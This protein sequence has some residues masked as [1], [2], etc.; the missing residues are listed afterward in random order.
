MTHLSCINVN[1]VKR[2][3]RSDSNA[4]CPCG[5]ILSSPELRLSQC[6]PAPPVSLT[7]GA[8]G[9]WHLALLCIP[10]IP[11]QASHTEVAGFLPM[12]TDLGYLEMLDSSLTPNPI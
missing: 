5:L 9:E 1:E 8:L 4:T 12:K 7:L 2:R 11:S 6:V 10:S 3:E